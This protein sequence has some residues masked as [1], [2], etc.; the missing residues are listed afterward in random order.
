M[1][2]FSSHGSS[3][4]KVVVESKNKEFIII[5]STVAQQHNC[6]KWKKMIFYSS[7]RWIFNIKEKTKKH[8]LNTYNPEYIC[9]HHLVIMKFG[10][11]FC[12]LY[13]NVH[14]YVVAD[15][16]KK[17][18]GKQFISVWIKE[19]PSKGNWHTNFFGE[20]TR[21]EC[22]NFRRKKSKG[23]V[24]SLLWMYTFSSRWH[25]TNYLTYRT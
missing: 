2:G 21:I 13:F 24:G 9:P 10:S 15:S 6:S 7:H 12:F 8:K 17:K 18:N 14:N 23:I 22:R 20:V 16:C 4:K 5:I 25:I 11:Q 3:T 19:N 1:I